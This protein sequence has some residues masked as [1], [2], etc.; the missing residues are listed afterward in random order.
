MYIPQIGER[1]FI[2]WNLGYIVD[3][4]IQA[5]IINVDLNQQLV[6]IKYD[7]HPQIFYISLAWVRP[8]KKQKL[9]SKPHRLTNI[10]K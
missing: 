2:G 6:A 5:T 10:F 9:E 1:V 7:Q 4:N 8:V 3:Y